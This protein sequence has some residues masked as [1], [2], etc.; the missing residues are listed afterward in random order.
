LQK[1]KKR[2]AF[3]GQY[4]LIL[5]FIFLSYVFD[6]DC[7]K[8][9]CLLIPTEKKR[10]SSQQNLLLR[11]AKAGS[12]VAGVVPVS[13]R[14]HT[15]SGRWLQIKMR[16]LTRQREKCGDTYNALVITSERLDQIRAL[17]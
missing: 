8:L 16:F 1:E 13:E 4:R 3:V 11:R 7:L 9:G 10:Q 12:I 6:V 14:K 17:R 5:I 15:R 2:A